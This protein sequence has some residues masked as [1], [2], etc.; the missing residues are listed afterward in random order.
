MSHQSDWGCYKQPIKLPLVKFKISLERPS[1]FCYKLN[2]VFLYWSYSIIADAVILWLTQYFVDRFQKSL[3]NAIN[4]PR[5]HR[6]WH[7]FTCLKFRMKRVLKIWVR[8]FKKIRD[9]IL[10]SEGIRK[11]TLRFFTKQMINSRSLG[12]R[13]VK[14]IEKYTLE[15]DKFSLYTVTKQT[16]WINLIIIAGEP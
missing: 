3:H 11:R 8:F 10:K 13:C 5:N 4:Q 14:G 12:S 6:Q 15:V 9:W 2:Q 7:T 1:L 16:C